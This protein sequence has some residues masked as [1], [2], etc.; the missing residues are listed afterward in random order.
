MPRSGI[1]RCLGTLHVFILLIL[2]FEYVGASWLWTFQQKLRIVGGE[3]GDQYDESGNPFRASNEANHH[4]DFGSNAM[5]IG[6]GFE[7]VISGYQAKDKGYVFVHNTDDGWD[8]QGYSVWTQNAILMPD[9]DSTRNEGFGKYMVAYN[10][11]I[12]VA[13]PESYNNLGAV[14]LFNGTMRSWTQTQVLIPE[15][16]PT[17][18]A[19]NP[20]E[21]DKFG[22]RLHLHKNRL[23]IGAQSASFKNVNDGVTAV[24][25]G[26][27]VY[28][29]EGEHTEL[30][31]GTGRY[32]WTWSFQA[33]LVA[34][35]A[36]TNNYFGENFAL[37]DDFVVVGAQ[38]DNEKVDGGIDEGN[39]GEFTGSAYVFQFET[40]KWS[41]QQKLIAGGEFMFYH[42]TR[43]IQAATQDIYYGIKKFNYDIALDENWLAVSGARVDAWVQP[44]E[45]VYLFQSAVLKVG[46]EEMHRWSLQQK[47]SPNPDPYVDPSPK[48]AEGWNITEHQTT[49]HL[50]HDTLVATMHTPDG[51]ETNFVYTLPE[52]HSSEHAG[53]GWSQQQVL[54]SEGNTDGKQMS[55]PQLWG[56]SMLFRGNHSIDMYTQYYPD[57]CL[58]L[59]ASDHFGDGWDKAVLTVVAPDGSND[60]FHPSCNQIDPFQVRYCPHQIQDSGV[61]TV[62]VFAPT[63][64]KFFWEISWQVILESTGEVYKGDF[65][66][67]IRFIFDTNTR[68]FSFMDAENRIFMDQPCYPCTSISDLTWNDQLAG[69]DL[70]FF[71]LVVRGAPYYISD[72]KGSKLVAKGLICNDDRNYECFIRIPEGVY[73]LRMGGGLFGREPP[74]LPYNDTEWLFPSKYPKGCQSSGYHREQFVF[75]IKDSAC[76]P[77]KTDEFPMHPAHGWRDALYANQRCYDEFGMPTQSPTKMPL[78]QYISM[79]FDDD[80]TRRLAQ[81]Q[82]KKDEEEV[83]LYGF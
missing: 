79:G 66:T 62:K 68:K 77:I 65:A 73:T 51:N 64:A 74:Y 52:Y 70:T 35:D 47:L 78:A 10:Q 59:W 40:G 41:Q 22:T 83:D 42:P 23:I 61:Y 75:E 39:G 55:N 29:Y 27:A 1:R 37:M 5:K 31:I 44:M 18:M 11:T 80:G 20:V 24:D 8:R 71:S 26:G 48:A 2:A 14:Y 3:V 60:T 46:T 21:G 76:T 15:S 17:N 12:V 72:V 81:E 58:L 49:V 6:R 82:D 43:H 9:Q 30:E 4:G 57:S 7:T 50:R 34:L 32:A 56:S 69:S 28:V 67:K 54:T 36:M 45:S 25:N 19:L 53:P 38:N 33:K 63:D 16:D 13:A